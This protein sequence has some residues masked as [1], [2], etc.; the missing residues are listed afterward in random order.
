MCERGMG[1]AVG[2][3]PRVL[4]E[5]TGWARE[6]SSIPV[7]V[8][9]TP[10]ITDILDPAM[11]AQRGGASGV[12]LVNTFKSV[13]G[14]D[15]DT[16]SPIPSVGG[17][18]TSG[19]YCGPA[20]KPIA[21]H[22]VTRLGKAPEFGLPV[23]GIGGI[24]TWED[25]LDFLLMGA[26]SLQVCTAAMH[27]G[28]RIVEEMRRGLEEWMRAKGY[29]RI[30]EYRGRALPNYEEWGDL[31][32]NFKIVAEIDPA[33]CIGCQLC[34]AACE[35]GAHQAIALQRNTRVPRIK[36]DECV[37]CNLCQIVC[38]VEG[39]I[40]MVEVDAGLP[41]ESWNERV[42]RGTAGAGGKH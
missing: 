22:M 10:N 8:K 23:S 1:S 34:F 18:G 9:L 16:F 11:A 5:I 15:H 38:P 36:R 30:E 3:E 6:F 21:L 27:Y 42:A 12:S 7:L 39:C 20:V 24:H 32:L 26:S 4:E 35:D 41:P 28:F 37:G 2:Q 14:I 29:A 31:D 33:T 40:T 19:G 25:A 13:I 17:L